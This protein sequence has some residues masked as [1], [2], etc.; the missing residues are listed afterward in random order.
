MLSCISKLSGHTSC[1]NV[2]LRLDHI[3]FFGLNRLGPVCNDLLLEF[4]MLMI[5]LGGVCYD[6]RE[7]VQVVD[8][9]S[10]KGVQLRSGGLCGACM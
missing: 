4:G 1:L 9:Y 5:S 2:G 8:H 6:E 3:T 7:S 10:H